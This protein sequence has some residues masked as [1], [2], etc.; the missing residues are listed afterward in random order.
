[1]FPDVNEQMDHIR[2]GTEEIISEEDLVRKIENSL[3]KKEPLIIKEGFDPTAPDLHIG[4]MVTIRKL[5]HFQDLGHTIVFL[6][7]D[8]TGMVGDPSGRSETRPMLTRA[9]VDANAETYKQQVFKVLNPDTTEIRFNSEWLGTLPIHKFME[10][11]S[12]YTVARMLERDDFQKRFEANKEISI[13][14][15][16]YCLLQA[17]DSVALKADVEIGGTDQKF[18]LLAGRTIMRRYNM[19]PQVVITLPLLVGTEGQHKM[20]KTYDNY[21]GV[22][23]PPQEMYG[24]T[25]SIADELILN[26]F[27]LATDVPATRIKEIQQQLA[28]GTNPRDVKRE[29]AKEIVTIYHS[30]EAA[31]EAEQAFDTVFVQ[32]DIPED[33]PEYILKESATISIIDL[34]TTTGLCSTNSEVKRL[35]QQGGLS[36]DGERV[37]DIKQVVTPADGMILK[38]GKR[39]FVRLKVPE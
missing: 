18:N 10:L 4:H 36:I 13:Q 23:E 34:F 8:F 30:S 16:L 39:N 38:K 20:S 33:I 27:E 14:E 7:G 37:S 6:I 29:L 31:K 11:S 19:E 32:K 15:F 2:R 12:L 3:S 25:M 17:Y 22:L 35:I 21:I 24:K 5:K 28:S 9:E 26:Y 1:M